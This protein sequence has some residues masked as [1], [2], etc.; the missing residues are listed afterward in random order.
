MELTPLFFAVACPAV[1][2]AGISKGGFGSGAAFASSTLLALVIPPGAAL[3][4]M[5]PLLMVMDATAL[6]AY[7]RLWD[8]RAALLLVVGG[9]PGVALGTVLLSAADP[10]VF[11]L[12]IG[13]IS[14]GFVAFQ[15]GRERG[16]LRPEGLPSGTFAGLGW[17]AVAGLTSFISHAGGP[18]AAVYLLSLRLD[19]A[20]YQATTVIVFWLVNI[21]KAVPYAALGAFDRTTLLADLI[22]WPLAVLGIW[23]GVRLHALVSER[24]FFRLTYALLLLTGGKLIADGLA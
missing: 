11:R 10:D 12:A 13:M 23:L 14:I 17:G 24:V 21:F 15:I 19:K 22:L 8:S 5:L 3:A 16:W 9:L 2:F 7:W 20:T 18:P 6:R 4:V 1:I